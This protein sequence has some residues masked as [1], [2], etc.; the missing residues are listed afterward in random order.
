[1]CGFYHIVE[2]PAV[3][4]T[5]NFWHKDHV[6]KYYYPNKINTKLSLVNNAV[7]GQDS[8]S[9]KV[10]ESPATDPLTNWITYPLW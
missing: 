10:T 4:R 5:E 2:S 9:P 7:A 8:G 6:D 1:M 3:S